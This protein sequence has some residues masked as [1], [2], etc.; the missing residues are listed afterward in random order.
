MK[1]QLSEVSK[2][3]EWRAH[4]RG[5][6]GLLLL[7]MT[8]W[9]VV[10]CKT[11]GQRGEP[12][13]DALRVSLEAVADAGT[14][15]DAGT[16]GCANKATPK[17]SPTIYVGCTGIFSQSYQTCA[18]RGGHVIF[19]TTNCTKPP[20]IY[21]TDPSHLFTDNSTSV[22]PSNEGVPK[23]VKSDASSS[24]CL[25]INDSTCIENCTA[26]STATRVSPDD[27][28]E[29]TATGSLDVATSGDGDVEHGKK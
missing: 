26:P 1:S 16:P 20:T 12:E 27:P 18:E 25:C 7:G 15:A 22:T 5:L 9:A 19:M 28:W 6:V 24:H 10:S 14:A 29:D 3:S 2:R 4:G 11:G 21:F 13:V 8:V 17:S 23:E